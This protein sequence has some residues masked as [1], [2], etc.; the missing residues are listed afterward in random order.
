M[1]PISVLLRAK[2]DR[3]VLTDAEKATPEHYSLSEDR[4]NTHPGGPS[5][6]LDEHGGWGVRTLARFY[7]EAEGRNVV[8][9]LNG[10]ALITAL[11]EVAEAAEDMAGVH[12]VDCIGSRSDIDANCNCDGQRVVA[13]LAALRSLAEARG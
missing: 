7:I 8:D 11:V 10:R 5:W 12:E 13:A 6:C 2:R 1:V 4:L 9:A 3:S